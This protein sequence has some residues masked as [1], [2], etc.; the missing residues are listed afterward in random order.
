MCGSKTRNGKVWGPLGS[1]GS[2]RA[3][4][5]GVGAVSRSQSQPGTGGR[6]ALRPR[7]PQGLAGGAAPAP[8]LAGRC[9]LGRSIDLKICPYPANRGSRVGG[10]PMGTRRGAESRPP[11]RKWVA[12]ET[13]AS[14]SRGSPGRL[15][16]ELLSSAT[17]SAPADPITSRLGWALRESSGKSGPVQ[18]ARFRRLRGLQRPW[19]ARLHPAETPQPGTSSQ[20]WPLAPP[21]ARAPLARLGAGNKLRGL[22]LGLG[23]PWRATAMGLSL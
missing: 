6:S 2:R 20:L 8:S 16:K 1:G 21:S 3:V 17:A 22:R 23:S 15:E 7:L 14:F 5:G 19:P 4:P 18:N 9:E 10:R 11:K 12:V 13:A